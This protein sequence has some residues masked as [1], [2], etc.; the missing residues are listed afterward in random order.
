[1]VGAACARELAV[2][3][4]RV[5]LVERGPTLGAA[6]SAAAGMLA[7]QIETEP[8][9]P[10][11]DLGIAGR[12][13]YVTLASELLEGTGLDIGLWGSGIANVATDDKTATVLRSRVA[14]QRQHGHLCDWLDAG[15]VRVRWPQL[16]PTCGALWAP[17]EATLDPNHLVRAMLLDAQRRGATLVQDEI[18]ALECD[19]GRVTGVRGREHYM[20]PDV[21][22]AVGAWSGRLDGLPRPLAV[23]PVRGQMATAPWPTGMPPG[24]FYHN[25]GY[26]LYREGVAIMGSTMEYVGFRPQVTEDG[27]ASIIEKVRPLHPGLSRSAITRS[28]A[29]LRPVSPDGL[30]IIGPEP[31]LRGLWYATGHGRNGILLAGIT[32]VIVRELLEHAPPREDIQLFRPERF[33]DW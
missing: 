18:V 19:D 25:H 29:G 28:W 7:P 21:I 2:A 11:F 17:R 27:L 30:P 32:G 26:M 22:L 10:L 16:G 8:E 4:R 3:G 1:M 14:L 6:W 15:E 12:E 9:A 23:E 33:W 5:L 31:R 13:R 24:V 20:A